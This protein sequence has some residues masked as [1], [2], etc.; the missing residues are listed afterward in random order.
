MYGS[1][2]NPT[3]APVP[4]VPFEQPKSL[5]RFGELSLWSTFLLVGGGAVASSVNR[6]FTTPRGQ[7]GQGFV[8]ALTLAET[9]LKEGGRVPAG[10]A[11]DVFGVSA[12]LLKSTAAADGGTLS[13]PIDTAIEIAD[14]VNIQ[15]NGILQWNFT[16]TTVDICSVYLAG[17]GGGTGGSI[18]TGNAADLGN[19]NNGFGQIWMYRKHPVALPG[20]STFAIELSFGS[21][22]AAISANSVAVRVSLLGYYK[23]VIEIG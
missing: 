19:L 3:G 5:Y 6:L 4:P 12:Q 1:T 10:V 16:Q 23:N 8:N 17:S 22:A 21:R 2:F 11:Y 15:N 20:N 18:S 14:L 13:A 7:V 9:S